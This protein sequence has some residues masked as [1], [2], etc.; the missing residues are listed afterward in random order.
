M[1]RVEGERGG[2]GE[3]GEG[4]RGNGDVRGRGRSIRGEAGGCVEV[5]GDER[6]VIDGIGE[7]D[8][9]EWR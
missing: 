2:P 6:Q 1:I 9:A 8:T 5:N 7:C 3:G 4:R